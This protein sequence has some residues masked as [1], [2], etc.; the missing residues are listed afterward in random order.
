MKILILE[1]SQTYAET[2]AEYLGMNGHEAVVIN[3][4]GMR[5]E[6]ALAAA[7]QQQPQR[8]L[9]DCRWN[10]TDRMDVRGVSFISGWQ[11]C[12]AVLMSSDAP[13]ANFRGDFVSKRAGLK[14]VEEA[15][16]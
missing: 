3:T 6:Q 5:V 13:P 10:D 16:L 4:T 11:G 9:V 7:K 8:I 12:K 2:V 15:L 14:A 1:N